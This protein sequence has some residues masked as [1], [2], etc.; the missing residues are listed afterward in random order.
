MNT[1]K[2]VSVHIIN[3]YFISFILS[4]Q[5][6]IYYFNFVARLNIVNSPIKKYMLIIHLNKIVLR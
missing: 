1:N 4:S 2:I 6:I 5:F 3:F